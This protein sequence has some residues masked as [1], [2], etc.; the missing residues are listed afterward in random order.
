[1]VTDEVW[2]RMVF[3]YGWCL[4]TDGVWLRMVLGVNDYSNFPCPMPNYQL[5]TTNYHISLN[6]IYNK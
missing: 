2:L 6:Y 3:G 5:P 4:A 1:M